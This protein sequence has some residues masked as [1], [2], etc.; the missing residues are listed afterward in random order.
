MRPQPTSFGSCIRY[1]HV[2]PTR[3]GGF[4]LLGSLLYACQTTLQNAVVV[5]AVGLLEQAAD[6]TRCTAEGKL[7]KA[8]RTGDLPISDF[9]GG[10]QLW[11]II[12]KR[13]GEF[14]IAF[15]VATTFSGKTCHF[16]CA[17]A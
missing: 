8:G 17:P 10:C 5:A 3:V 4:P 13:L 7:R 12:S 2:T 1:F 16:D 11:C 14:R 6:M 9:P 15:L